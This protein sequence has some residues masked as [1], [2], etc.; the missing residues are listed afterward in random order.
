[1]KSLAVS[2]CFLMRGDLRVVFELF[3]NT[4]ATTSEI[5]LVQLRLGVRKWEIKLSTLISPNAFILQKANGS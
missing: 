2:V 5:S 1:M 3:N 4:L